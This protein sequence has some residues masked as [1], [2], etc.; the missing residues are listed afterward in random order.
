[1]LNTKKKLQKNAKNNSKNRKK[2][3]INATKNIIN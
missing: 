1:M 3:L 2:K